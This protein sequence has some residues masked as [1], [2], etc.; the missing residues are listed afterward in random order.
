[1]LPDL[2][3]VVSRPISSMFQGVSKAKGTITFGNSF[4]RAPASIFRGISYAAQE[5]YDD[6]ESSYRFLN[7][8]IPQIYNG[9]LAFGGFSYRTTASILY[10]FL[11]RIY[12]LGV[13][14]FRGLNIVV[15]RICNGIYTLVVTTYRAIDYIIPRIFHGI[16]EVGL[17][18]SRVPGHVASHLAA[19]KSVV[20]SKTKVILCSIAII[21]FVPYIITRFRN[22]PRPDEFLRS[23][24]DFNYSNPQPVYP[25]FDFEHPVSVRAQTNTQRQVTRPS[26]SV[27]PSV[28]VQPRPDS[29]PCI[30]DDTAIP[31]PNGNS[32][33]TLIPINLPA[34]YPSIQPAEQENTTGMCVICIEERSIFAII[35][36]GH[37]CFCDTCV[38]LYN[39]SDLGHHCP[40]CRENVREYLRIFFT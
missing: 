8:A 29:R 4:Y 2:Y 11:R 30:V 31:Q 22:R 1:M 37:L 10:E 28:P 12:R 38:D 36:C 16:C 9:M 19:D 7:T 17:W 34:T 27:T 33:T 18:F 20:S 21:I 15:P 13:A 3:F 24:R 26:V 23:L 39:E 5:T 14:A 35:P 40:V 25:N 6:G 32:S